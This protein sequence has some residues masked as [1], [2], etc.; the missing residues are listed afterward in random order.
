MYDA[1]TRSEKLAAPS[2]ELMTAGV[3]V[4]AGPAATLDVAEATAVVPDYEVRI[5][6]GD[7]TTVPEGGP[8]P[9]AFPLAT[10]TAPLVLDPAARRRP[11]SV[12]SATFA[13][14]E[15][16]WRDADATTGVGVGPPGSYRQA[17][18]ELRATIAA[19]PTA[20]ARRRVAPT[21][22]LVES[23]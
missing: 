14:G 10:T 21:H 6:D 16:I 3:N 11:R 23:S 13:V 17:V 7:A 19:D 15:T 18:L 8:Q 20:R 5:L 9:L 12:S 22:A 4:A 2:F 1:M